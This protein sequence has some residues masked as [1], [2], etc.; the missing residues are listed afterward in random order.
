MNIP[1][2]AGADLSK[3]QSKAVTP[4]ST[5]Q[6]AGMN[7][8]LASASESLS[9]NGQQ[10]AT[11]MVYVTVTLKA[12]NSSANNFSGLPSDYM[13]LQSGDSKSPPSNNST[14]PILVASQSTG[15]GM[16]IFAIQQGGTSFTLL[17][18]AQQSSPPIN[19][20]SV[21]FQIQ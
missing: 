12:V 3:Y 10:A 14:F 2:V 20:T 17:M 15:S 19:A 7:W 4:N 16:V 6:Y 1:L 9:A 21:T 13:R 5:F 18:L 11:G 8:T